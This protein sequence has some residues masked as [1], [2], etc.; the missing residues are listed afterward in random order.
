[1]NMP[2]MAVYSRLLRKSVQIHFI[3]LKRDTKVMAERS[4]SRQKVTNKP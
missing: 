3:M 4:H 1:M 2:G